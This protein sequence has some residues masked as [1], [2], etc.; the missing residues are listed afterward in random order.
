[1]SRYS[2]DMRSACGEQPDESKKLGPRFLG[3]LF[4]AANLGVIAAYIA[5]CER[6]GAEAWVAICMLGGLPAILAGAF[7]G[8]LLERSP[9]WSRGARLSVILMPS[10]AVVLCCGNLMQ[11][12]RYVPFGFVSTVVFGILLEITVRGAKPAM[13]RAVEID[14]S[15]LGLTGDRG[16]QNDLGPT[17][18]LGPII[19]LAPAVDARSIAWRRSLLTP[20]KDPV[21]LGMVLGIANVVV[22]AIGIDSLLDA[23]H[24]GVASQVFV[25]GV[26]PGVFGGAAI[27]WIAARCYDWPPWAR[28]VVLVAPA[29]A[30]VVLLGDMFNLMQCVPPALV[31][32]VAA[33]LILEQRTREQTVPVARAL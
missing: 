26:L 25:Y 1:M 11:L 9:E 24:G 10:L 23:Y 13:G 4:G 21:T 14:V 33:A 32:T 31:P 2:P 8:R 6:G 30:V 20:R 5:V 17:N 16:P 28:R 15:D 18:D 19:D 7:A 3:A 12:G 22:I 29:I 27:G